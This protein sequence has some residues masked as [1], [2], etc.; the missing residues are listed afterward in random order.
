MVV[1]VLA[2]LVATVWLLRLRR[3]ARLVRSTSTWW[4]A[5]WWGRWQSDSSGPR[6]PADSS[7]TGSPSHPL[8]PSLSALGLRTTGG[9]RIPSATSNVGRHRRQVRWNR[10]RV[11]MASA[12]TNVAETEMTSSD[13]HPVSPGQPPG[14]THR[15][16]SQFVLG[17]VGLTLFAV[18]ASIAV[19]AAQK[20]WVPPPEL[21]IETGPGLVGG[22][23]LAWI[24]A[25]R[26]R[27]PHTSR[28]LGEDESS[29]HTTHQTALHRTLSFQLTCLNPDHMA[30]RRWR[31]DYCNLTVRATREGFSRHSRAANSSTPRAEPSPVLDGVTARPGPG[32][33][34][35]SRNHFNWTLPFPTS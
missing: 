15:A 8:S 11:H 4:S 29:L 33:A 16:R 26:L 31:E 20:E 21:S 1:L 6:N 2:I 7:A 30:A 13:P 9:G 24:S 5:E 25:P 10:Y 32:P 23:P 17:C 28:S 34:V 27:S 12:A 18:G 22:R 3:R 14:R 19:A 35:A